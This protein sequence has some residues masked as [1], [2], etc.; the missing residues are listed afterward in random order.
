MDHRTSA[1][2]VEALGRNREEALGR[3]REE[4]FREEE[5][6]KEEEDQALAALTCSVFG[7]HD[8]C[9]LK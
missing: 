8:L 3:Y 4:A 1:E 6:R 9:L 5:A 7:P 2:E